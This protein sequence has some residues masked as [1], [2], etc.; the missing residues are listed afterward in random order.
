MEQGVALRFHKDIAHWSADYGTTSL[1]PHSMKDVATSKS[2][3]AGGTSVG[4]RQRGAVVR[5]R[6]D[7]DHAAWRRGMAIGGAS[8]QPRR[9]RA[10][11]RW[12]GTSVA[13]A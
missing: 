8:L 11:Q 12:A 7:D 3:V 1:R 9:Q 10:E 4:Q 6:H 2:I 13:H 5:M